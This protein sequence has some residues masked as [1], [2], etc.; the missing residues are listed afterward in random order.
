MMMLSN[1]MPR[2]DCIGGYV[3]VLRRKAN[4][5]SIVNYCS[6][7]STFNLHYLLIIMSAPG[8]SQPKLLIVPLTLYLALGQL[9]VRGRSRECP[10]TTP[11]VRRDGGTTERLR[12]QTYLET[13]LPRQPGRRA[14]R[15]RSSRRHATTT[16]I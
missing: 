2:I 16:K 10:V 1:E 13:R 6:P 14:Y 8:F 12:R 7:P 15:D 4:S 3:K 5:N 9:K 11:E